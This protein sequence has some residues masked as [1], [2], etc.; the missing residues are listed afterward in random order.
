MQV[1]SPDKIRNLA[2]AG[3]NASGKTTLASALLYTSG[4]V[5]RMLRIEDKNTLTDFDPE[6]M[7]RGI[8]INV[9]PAFVP[10][11]G[12]K[13]NLLDCPGYGIFFTETRAGMRAA[14]SVL[15]R[16]TQ[17]RRQSTPKGCGGP[18]DGHAG[19]FYLAKGPEAP[20][21]A[22]PR[23]RSRRFDQGSRAATERSEQTSL[24][25]RPGGS[26][27]TA[28]P[29]RQGRAGDRH[30]FRLTAQ[31]AALRIHLMRMGRTADSLLDA[32]SRK[33]PDDVAAPRLVPLAPAGAFSWLLG[34]C[35]TTSR[36]T[37]PT[38]CST[39]RP[40]VSQPA[41][42]RHLGPVSSR[43]PRERTAR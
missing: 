20:L 23:A 12:H 10:W 21:H 19:I 27:P 32:S 30:S 25:G 7:E 15:C 6:E 9:A 17:W 22:R 4:V 40:R 5:N 42:P 16:S 13:V 24:R 8:S 29:R 34:A 26:R 28:R 31:A 18:R 1:D 36:S 39:S 11:R 35:C 3:H 37:L 2:L 33:D 38:L 43:R 41:V 14:D